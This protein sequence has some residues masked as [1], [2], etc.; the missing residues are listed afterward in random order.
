MPADRRVTAAWA[1]CAAVLL[2]VTYYSSASVTHGFVSYFAA[3][4]LLVTGQLGPSAYDDAWFG[5]YVKTITG[6]NVLEIFIPNP[7]TMSLMAAPVSM[8]SHQTA[9][10]I[11]LFASVTAFA[12]ATLALLRLRPRAAGVPSIAIA[13]VMMLNPS[14]FA[15]IRVGQ[16]YLIIFAL[17]AATAVHLLRGR[18][19]SAGVSL[20]LA[21]ILKLSGLGLLAIVAIQRRR[22]VLTYALLT[23]AILAI[24]ITPFIDARMWIAF[25]Q[26]VRDFTVR[27]TGSVTAYQTT[28]GMFRHVCAADPAWNPVPA[29]NCSAVA[30][31][32][33]WTL[34]AIA[35]AVTAVA[36]LR[37]RE[38]IAGWIA[39]GVCLS[40]LVQPAAPEPHFVLL[41]IPLALI[42]MPLWIFTIV[43]VLMIV[44]L[45]WTAERFTTGWWAVMAYPRLY[46]AWMLWA[47]SI[48][49][50]SRVSAASPESSTSRS[51]E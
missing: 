14:V 26:A 8:F 15:N 6:S 36:A 9:R 20:G 48:R 24:A 1:V 2:A 41:A 3:A 35:S 44:P 33:P 27:P 32:M 17:L 22:R 29:A 45:E 10:A 5:A 11:W 16:G 40:E 50:T 21:A 30:F 39:A 28:L 31:V 18:A 38:A 34:L 13:A 19:G 4:R 7:P 12:L 46:A 25:P 43:A 51:R 47:L 49:A 42:D 37:N 23:A